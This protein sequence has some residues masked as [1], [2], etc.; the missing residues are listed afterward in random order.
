MI[1]SAR[2]THADGMPLSLT[3]RLSWHRSGSKRKSCCCAD[4]AAAGTFDR[5]SSHTRPS[6]SLAAAQNFRRYMPHLKQGCRDQRYR[7]SAAPPALRHYIAN[8]R[9]RGWVKKQCWARATEPGWITP[10]VFLR[11]ALRGRVCDMKRKLMLDY[12]SLGNPH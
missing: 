6:T 3:A 2:S 12:L 5:H 8:L 9:V 10:Q 11:M 7:R 1:K 4:P